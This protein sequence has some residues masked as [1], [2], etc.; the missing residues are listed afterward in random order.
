LALQRPVPC[1]FNILL[2]LEIFFRSSPS[3]RG[4]GPAIVA[5][6]RF[7][8]RYAEKCRKT[9]ASNVRSGAVR[10]HSVKI[11]PDMH[12][13]PTDRPIACLHSLLFHYRSGAMRTELGD[14]QYCVQLCRSWR[15]QCLSIRLNARSRH[16]IGQDHRTA[17][18]LTTGGLSPESAEPCD[19]HVP[20]VFTT[21]PPLPQ[22]PSASNRECPRPS[23]LPCPAPLFSVLPSRLGDSSA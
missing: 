11:G 20:R 3:Q 4:N 21:V 9:K 22:A 17:D 8:G 19:P 10:A 15:N 2:F 23:R 1:R 5:T 7:S 14:Q 6:S 16:P 12:C 18:A 13:C